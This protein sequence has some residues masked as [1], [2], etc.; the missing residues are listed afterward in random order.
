[1]SKGSSTRQ[2]LRVL[3]VPVG[4]GLLVLLV[5]RSGGGK[6]IEE[7]RAVGWG[8]V[9]I[10]ALGGVSHLLRTLGWRRTFRSDIRDVSL[11]NSFGLRL[12]SEAIGN[13]GF[14]GQ[15][16]GDTMRVSLLTPNV[17]IDDRISSVALDRVIYTV[18][19]AIVGV[20]G[21]L[22]CVLLLPLPGEWRTYA[23]VFAAIMGVFIIFIFVSFARG[24]RIL[25]APARAIQGL[26]W[27]RTWLAGTVPLIESVEDNL[28]TFHSQSPASFWAAMSLYI[29]SQ[30]MAIAEVYLLLLFMGVRVTFSGA[31]VIEAFTKLISVVGALNPGNIGTYEG[32]NLLLARMLH[33]AP[34]A[35][36]TLALCRR[37]R[38]LFWAGVGAACIVVL[39]RGKERRKPESA[40]G[41]QS[42]DAL[43]SPPA[44]AMDASELDTRNALAVII[45]VDCRQVEN[46][47]LPALARV[48]RLPALLRTIL[49]VEALQ[50]SRLVISVPSSVARVVREELHRSRR[51]P[52]SVEWRE[53]R[54]D[55]DL[56]ALV[57]EVASSSDR[58]VLLSG[59]NIYKPALLTTAGDSKVW[60]DVISFE[61]AGE[62][63]A[64][65]CVWSAA[66]LRLPE[67]I[68]ANSVG[69][70]QS[71]MEAKD[72]VVIM[73]APC[74][75]WH[76]ILT[77]EDL[78]AAEHKL[79]S[80]M[81]K[82]TDGIFARFNRRISIPISRQLIKTPITP[83]AV[84]FVILAVSITAGVFFAR[85][86]Y[87]NM[88]AGAL[89]SVWASI[90]DGC[91]GE[92]ARFRLQ[93]SRLGSWLDTICDYLY[94]L[95]T[96]VGIAWGLNR[97][98]RSNAY[99]TWAALLVIG[100]VFSFFVV[101][102]LRRRMAAADPGKFLALF[103]RETETRSSNPLL[104]VARNTEFIIRRCF[105]PY[106]LLVAAAL[107]LIKGAFV[108]T[109]ISANLVWIIV[110]Y[111]SFALS[112]NETGAA[113]VQPRIKPEEG[114]GVS[115]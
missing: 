97:S 54:S 99:L 104:F 112:G 45:A 109:A 49:S 17:P 113:R 78:A 66:V 84:T 1:M 24:W 95:T 94:Y 10:L 13:F 81:F 114:F 80:W 22:A 108:I 40:D 3:A 51:L 88:V 100:M 62:A 35:G 50:P 30:V 91:D 74:E 96:F 72:D 87:W 38:S 11:A 89:L 5:A 27:S 29:G 39:S 15:V 25:S 102:W 70:L 42:R 82:P 57:N 56:C 77:Q 44:P 28:L 16:V 98:S 20:I 86:G 111:S 90:L 34:A 14:A 103:Q 8:M 60:S 69:D 67:H 48:G 61:T 73:Q 7:A 85:G 76:A 4:V 36:L 71:C 47:F 93:S 64:L 101:S 110:L 75:E 83:N 106:A 32:G 23:L 58:I 31:L 37:A 92:V 59:S 43:A 105:F 9:L 2:S 115:L 63:A 79:D 21:I 107:N 46:G 26:P 19:S 6:V 68:K 41:S 33:L 52:K 53:R 18:T 55:A 65:C 12:I